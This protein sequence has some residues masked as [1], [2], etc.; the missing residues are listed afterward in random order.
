MNDAIDQLLAQN[1]HRLPIS[2]HHPAKLEKTNKLEVELASLSQHQV[3]FY[4]Y[5]IKI[6]LPYKLIRRQLCSVDILLLELFNSYVPQVALALVAMAVSFNLTL[7]TLSFSFNR[8][9]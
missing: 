9:L 3:S 5:K 2:A 7:Y 1:D 8:M 6:V 4:R